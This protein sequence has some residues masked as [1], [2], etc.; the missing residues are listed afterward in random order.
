MQAFVSLLLVFLVS[1]ALVDPAPAQERRP[2]VDQI[3][4][5]FETIV[6]GSEF[7]AFAIKKDVVS[8]WSGEIGLSIQ[9]RA[10]NDLVGMASQHLKTLSKLTGIRFRQVKAADQVQSIN[11]LFLKRAEM[12]A[13]K[14]PGIDPKV[15]EVL[16][17][18]GGC[19]YMAFNKPPER[20]V[21]AII[22][23]N[24]ERPREF[25]N[26]C[27][28]EELTQS[29]GLHNDSNQLRPSIF[30]DKDRITRL[31]RS[32]EILVRTL[33]DPRL[34]AG[35]PKAEALKIASRIIADWDRRLP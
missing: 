3:T 14:G 27:I 7:G 18:G 34:P 11:L 6:F 16:A 32:D 15:V 26:S 30:S 10:T 23:V 24:I 12:G 17:M 21:K 1:T 29:L 19:Y 5:Y 20:I 2:S 31:S 13:I 35:T 8:R 9:G 33:Y 22:V 25:T 4:T 28:L